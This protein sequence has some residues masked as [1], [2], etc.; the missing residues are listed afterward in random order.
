MIA[1]HH[2]AAGTAGYAARREAF[3]DRWCDKASALLLSAGLVGSK[4]GASV[5]ALLNKLLG[6][7]VEMQGQLFG[8]FSAILD[9]VGF[10]LRLIAVEL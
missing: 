2:V 8:Y 1:T 10:V 9:K 3:L 5:H 4:K 6:M 7:R